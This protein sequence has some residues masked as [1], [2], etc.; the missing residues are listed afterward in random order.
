VKGSPLLR[1]AL[2]QKLLE[3]NGLRDVAVMVTAGANQ[4]FVNVVLTL[5]DPSDRVV[6]F[7]PYYFNHLMALQMTGSGRSVIFG[8]CNAQTLHP[9]LDWLEQILSSSE[10]PKMVVLVN[11]CNPTGVA[12]SR[13]E[14]IRASQLCQEAGA[15]LVLD[16]TYEVRYRGPGV[17][18]D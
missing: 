8:E 5:C 16:N 7:R 1:E 2:Q 18:A 6:L 4:A 11:P 12:L 9:D 10:R 13:E 15:W 17:E 14:V 3:E